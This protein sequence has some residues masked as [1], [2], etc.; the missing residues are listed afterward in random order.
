L[1]YADVLFA[2]A[3]LGDK[4]IELINENEAARS[5]VL[6]L[7]RNRIKKYTVP[8]HKDWV[9]GILKSLGVDLMDAN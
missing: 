3:L 5:T 4:G 7:K 1:H 2:V 9:G 8:W 6:S